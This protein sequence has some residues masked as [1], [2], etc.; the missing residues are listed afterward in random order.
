VQND[1][2]LIWVN[3]SLRPAPARVLEGGIAH[4]LCHID[5]D[6]RTGPYARRLAWD[7]Y[8]QSRWCRIREE[9]ATERRV[10]ELGYGVQLLAF[11]QFA[12]RL[13][14]SFSREHGLLYA[15]ISRSVQGRRGLNRGASDPRHES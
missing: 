11:I 5:A 6:V 14:Y 13:G 3:E 12:H 1:Q 7:R 2:F 9:R 15:E 10:L 8:L 4:E